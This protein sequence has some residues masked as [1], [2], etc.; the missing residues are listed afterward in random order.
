MNVF[1]KFRPEK[2]RAEKNYL[3]NQQTANCATPALRF[4]ID[5]KLCSCISPGNYSQ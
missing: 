1:S 5:T 3:L 4:P 2:R